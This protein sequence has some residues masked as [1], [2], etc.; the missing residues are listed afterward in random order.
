MEA[1]GWWDNFNGLVG[2]ACYIWRYHT[3]ALL[4]I[5]R[6]CLAYVLMQD[7]EAHWLWRTAEQDRAMRPTA[8]PSLAMKE[9]RLLSCA[10]CW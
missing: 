2:V 5:H 9:L 7:L 8:E 10:F 3:K 6:I 1:M 4:E